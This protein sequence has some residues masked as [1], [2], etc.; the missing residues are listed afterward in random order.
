VCNWCAALTAG[1]S[2]SSPG[3]GSSGRSLSMSC[4]RQQ[5][6]ERQAPA[7]MLLDAHCKDPCA[8]QR[9]LGFEAPFGNSAIP[10]ASCT[11]SSKLKP[12]SPIPGMPSMPGSAPGFSSSACKTPIQ[13]I[14]IRKIRASIKKLGERKTLSAGRRQ[15]AHLRPRPSTTPSRP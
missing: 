2:P 12:S 3:A 1:A 6:Q 7:A 8:K 11:M 15:S 14:D 5:N 9:R 10:G 4:P 13:G